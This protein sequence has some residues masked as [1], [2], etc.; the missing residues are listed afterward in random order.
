MKKNF[1]KIL[2]LILC[3]V[4]VF[5]LVACSGGAET[6]EE[7]EEEA[8]SG[9]A[10]DEGAGTVT[11]ESVDEETGF[12]GTIAFGYI[13]FELGEFRT[14]VWEG[15]Q[16]ACEERGYTVEFGMTDGDATKQRSYTEAFINQGVDVM[17]DF[18]CNP[19]TGAAMT[20][21]CNDAD[22][23]MISIDCDY[24]EGSYFFGTNNKG[25]AEIN[26]KSL[27][28]YAKANW[29]GK[30]DKFIRVWSETSGE[31]IGWRTEGG[32]DAMATVLPE[33][34]DKKADVLSE[35]ITDRDNLVTR[36]HAVDWVTMNPDA[37][38]VAVITLC[39]PHSQIVDEAVR[40]VGAEDKFAIA[41]CNCDLMFLQQLIELKGETGWYSSINFRPWNYGNLICNL[42]E[43]LMMGEEQPHQTF[44]DL[45]VCTYENIDEMF[46]EVWEEYATAEQKAERA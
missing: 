31:V 11:D 22:V 38:H 24:G 23:F 5:S 14:N 28:E 1:W 25:C 26:G 40:S 16:K 42:A 6:P 45:P 10:L 12:D 44:F 30:I 41:S 39:D 37:E 19:E 35:I 9:T 21:L 43:K 3:L 8:P 2:S 34:A 4:M 17:V 15:M 7:S 36:Q 20:K 18:Y 33:Y 46:P 13:E 29:D 27:G 32:Y